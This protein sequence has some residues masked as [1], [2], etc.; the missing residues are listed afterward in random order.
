[1][2]SESN[3]NDLSRNE[4]TN[5]LLKKIR[6]G[7]TDIRESFIEANSTFIARIVSQIL[8]K[9]AV[10]KNSKEYDAA[11]DAF[12]YC[13]DNYDLESDVSFL[14]YSDKVMKEWIYHLLW[15][16]NTGK[17]DT[18]KDNDKEYLY[19]NSENKEQIIIL[20][21]KL[22]EYGITL[23]DLF[24]LGPREYDNI[25]TCLRISSYISNDDQL[26]K[27]MNSK[28]A[29]PFDDLEDKFKSQKKFIEKHKEYIIALSLILSS[30]LKIL[31]SYLKNIDA[32]KSTETIGII[33]ELFKREAIVMNF[34]GQFTIIKIDKTNNSVIGKQVQ[35]SKDGTKVSLSSFSKYA[36]YAACIVGICALLVV[37]GK[38]LLFSNST[39][40]KVVDTSKVVATD[41]NP[42]D[43]T[44]LVDDNEIVDDTNV[45]DDVAPTEIVATPVVASPEVKNA[46]NS[47]SATPKPSATP[48][49]IDKR[50]TN[51]KNA[52][53]KPG[54][55]RIKK[56]TSKVKSTPKNIIAENPTSKMPATVSKAS[57]SIQKKVGAV[58]VPSEVQISCTSNTVIY[59]N[60]F[61][62][63]MS[64]DGGNNGTTLELFEDNVSILKYNIE[65]KTP[66]PQSISVLVY[67]DSIGQKAYR[68]KLSNKYGSIYSRTMY[69]NIVDN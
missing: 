21:Q 46:E 69:I 23:R 56:V 40:D 7:N 11:L 60:N 31:K 45:D 65:D 53:P 36:I 26:F 17:I 50:Q 25:S 4:N 10:P 48:K 58:G 59:K 28:K 63:S 1:M 9:S 67:A 62:V 2:S 38:I 8:D 54:R 55:K 3:T 16:E 44:E 15:E 19:S 42:Q 30:D 57:P 47:I 51:K 33:L 39:N 41:T 66:E 34:Q 37:G 35:L 13:I 29:I 6:E 68:W 64:M 22:W 5:S 27:K 43:G 24:F 61:T 14:E 32:G 12:N 52:T 20:K 18:S 49:K